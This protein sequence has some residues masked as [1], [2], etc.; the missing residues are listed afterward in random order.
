MPVLERAL[1]LVDHDYAVKRE[2][3]E[4][5]RAGKQGEVE[6]ARIELANRELE[7]QLAEIRAPIDGRRHGR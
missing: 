5:K 4:L 3:L 7:R 2:E 6:A 1:E